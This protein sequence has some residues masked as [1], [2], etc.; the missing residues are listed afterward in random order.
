LI[1]S[2]DALGWST[3]SIENPVAGAPPALLAERHEGDELPTVLSY[4]HG[5]VIVGQDDRWTCGD[6]PWRLAHEGDRLYGRGTADNKAQHT[7]NMLA[8]AAA[9]AANGGELG[10]NAK[11][12]IEMGEEAGSAGLEQLVRDHAEL[13]AADV[14]IASDGPRVRPD[15][16]T[17]SL[18]CRGAVNVDLV[19]DLRHGAH[20][21]GNWGGLIADPGL[22]LA[23]ALATIV[24][25][26]G[27]LLV[28]ELVAVPMSD[29]VRACLDDVEV[30]GGAEGPQIDTWWGQP[31]LSPPQRVFAANTFN[32]LAFVAGNPSKVVNAIPPRAVAHCQL[33]MVAGTDPDVV[34]P[35]LR[36]HLDARGFERV[37]VEPPPPGNAGAF[38]ARRTEPDHPW[39]VFVRDSMATTMDGRPA[40][41]PS[42]GGSV[43]NHVFTDVLDLPTIWIPH[44]YPSCSQHAPDEHVLVSTCRSGLGVMAGLFADIGA[45]GGPP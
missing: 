41:L 7:I 43:P 11:Y 32:V 28:D 29:A 22:I 35:A 12:L 23:N 9:T 18:G 20:H 33:R 17:M 27:E 45:T 14:L 24:G 39:A 13:F 42:I 37:R 26:T 31:G 5:D 25:P 40:V 38:P 30:D 1:P 15:R 36:R 6:G 10:F 8:F 16:P 2:F 4:G 3:R 19:V 21:S 44:S 34:A